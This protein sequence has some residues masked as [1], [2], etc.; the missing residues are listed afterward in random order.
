MNDE[1]TDYLLKEIYTRLMT[2]YG[3]QHWWPAES[4]FEMMVGAILTQSTAWTNVEKAIDNLKQAQ[5]LSPEVIRAMSFSELAEIIKLSGYY[6]VKSRKL[7]SLVYWL[8]EAF[9]DNI[10]NMAKC[11]TSDLREQ[12]LSVYGIG[13]ETADSILL[14]AAEKPVFVIDTY[15]R[16]IVSRIGL[17]KEEDNYNDYQ[18]LFMT[19][20]KADVTIYNE[21][22]ALLVQLAK[23]ACNKKPLCHKCCLKDICS[24][25]RGS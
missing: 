2:G 11:E 12:L 15:T 24:F 13:P 4:A 18:K 3:P 6:N 22:H 8:G 21:Y 1:K 16:R 23:D 7:K 14:Y 5:A 20:I 17:M 19:N 9:A 10:D 25:A